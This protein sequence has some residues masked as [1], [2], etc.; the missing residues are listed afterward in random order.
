[1]S[2]NFEPYVRPQE[3]T[4]HTGTKFADVASTAGHGL[5]FGAEKFS[6]SFSHFTP[7]QLTET[8]HNYELTPNRETT[9]FIDYR[10]SGIGSN[11][12]GPRLREE[13]RLPSG[14]YVF[15]IRVE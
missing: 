12:C 15:D 1:M 7:E 10:T 13:Y 5:F 14:H 9:V 8:R 3:N 2:E 4:A 11:S 6:F